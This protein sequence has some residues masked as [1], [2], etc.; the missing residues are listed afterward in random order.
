MLFVLCYEI[1]INI[2]VFLFSL[3]DR[4]GMQQLSHRQPPMPSHNPQLFWGGPGQSQPPIPGVYAGFGNPTVM[5]SMLHNAFHFARP[6]VVMGPMTPSHES[7][8]KKGITVQPLSMANKIEKSNRWLETEVE[9]LIEWLESP[10]MYEQWKS[11]GV[12]GSGGSTKPSGLSKAKIC[13]KVIQKYLSKNGVEK[14]PAQIQNKIGY[15]ELV[16]RKAYD[17][18]KSTGEGVIEKDIVM[19]HPHI[20]AKID[21]ICPYFWRLGEF[22]KNK[23]CTNSPDV[24]DSMDTHEGGTASILENK[25]AI[26]LDVVTILT[27][28]DEEEMEI[29]EESGVPE[30]D[31]LG[32]QPLESHPVFEEPDSPPPAKTF[33]ESNLSQPNSSNSHMGKR[34]QKAT[35]AD[36]SK[37]ST[38]KTRA[39][40]S[41]TK[42]SL[43][44]QLRKPNIFVDVW[45]EI[46]ES[47]R[48]HEEKVLIAKEEWQKRNFELL[49]ERLEIRK[50]ESARKFEIQQQELIL[51][52]K[53]ADIRMK[54]VE[55]QNLMLQ[56]EL[57]KLNH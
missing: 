56:M 57:A 30:G 49:K 21:S 16:Y 36:S 51:R 35:V 18:C 1:D 43:P 34:K 2:S 22:M 48:H 12:K 31:L 38:K 42:A 24:S 5:P 54:E 44:K 3:T 19:R 41:C 46:G 40:T 28:S 20:I 11:A 4:I 23:S 53:E 29:E 50:Q 6:H 37:R 13:S 15:M 14:T 33:M 7:C 10:G 9:V 17:Y 25:G 8:K 52:H 39:T 55:N 45:K 27:S 26:D 47:K 32:M